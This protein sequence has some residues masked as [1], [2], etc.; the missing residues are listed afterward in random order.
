MSQQL[1]SKLSGLT[2]PLGGLRLPVEQLCGGLLVSGMTGSGKTVS[3]VNPL[4]TQFAL[5]KAKQPEQKAA[6][7]YFSLKGRPHDQFL[8]S[9]P[10]ARQQDVVL[11]SHDSPCW[12][13]LF[14]GPNWRSTEEVNGAVV[15][16]VEEFSQHLGNE[17]NTRRHDLFWERQRI[18]YMN[19][20]LALEVRFSS[21]LR[22]HPTLQRLVSSNVLEALLARMDIFFEY[23][24]NMSPEQLKVYG[25]NREEN[26]RAEDVDWAKREY[27]KVLPQEKDWPSDPRV[28]EKL[29][30]LLVQLGRPPLFDPSATNLGQFQAALTEESQLRLNSL[31][32][33]FTR[34]S[35]ETRYS[36]L[37]D[38][39]GV[40]DT[41]KTAETS[42]YL[43][44]DGPS[45]SE[46]P[47]TL[48]EVI[49]T[50][51]ILV[52]DLPLADGGNSSLPVLLALKLAL[53]GR[54]LGRNAAQFNGEP[55]CQRPALVVIDEFQNL[56]SAGRTGGED[57]MLAQ[58]R[59]HGVTV[60]LATQSLSL[61]A[62]VLQ[63]DSK[64]AAL[65]ANCRT[66][67]FGRNGDTLTNRM[68][69]FACGRLEVGGVQRAPVWH[70]G[71]AFRAF[72]TDTMPGE[73]PVVPD[74]RF[75]SLQTGQFYAATADGATHWLDLRH[76]LPAPESKLLRP[77][78]A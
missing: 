34:L 22:L 25:L 70:G 8:A 37:A 5:L 20:L 78:V 75:A 17:L 42:R 49:H 58:C 18:R 51:K 21:V 48:E 35:N 46:I 31:V 45:M 71:A 7:V 1:S 24:G 33:E 66:K 30:K 52:V 40:L 39:R 64:L 27:A 29:V 59:E 12:V 69:S 77:P 65:V 4:A 10:K 72:V 13:S 76:S 68:A 62:G 14:H 6:I 63:N 43:F 28:A 60:L 54:L 9:L 38:I 26:L 67:V 73:A 50:G 47:L 74:N 23:C 55:L 2:I 44:G 19:A 53:F 36:I 32:L 16:F 41:F 11:V 61:L 15:R 57:L 3:V 56:V